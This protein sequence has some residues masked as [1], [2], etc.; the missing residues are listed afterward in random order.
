MDVSRHLGAQPDVLV[1]R[2]GFRLIST[3]RAAIPV[4]RVRLNCRV[5]KK[6][7][8][9]T[10]TEFVLRAIDLGVDTSHDITQLLNLPVEVVDGVLG[11]LLQ[12]RHLLVDSGSG[13]SKFV[14]TASGRTLAAT[15]VD[16]RVIPAI[17]TYMIDGLSGEPLA[18]PRE[19]II[20]TSEVDT[21]PRLVLEADEDPSLEFGPL[22]SDRFAP[23]EPVGADKGVSLLTILDVESTTKQYIDATILLFESKQDASDLF[24]RVC[25]DGRADHRIESLVRE[26]GI[27]RSMRVEARIDED[28][29]RVDRA[30]PGEVSGMRADD[31]EVESIL[32]E[33]WKLNTVNLADDDD[34]S[35]DVRRARLRSRLHQ[36]PVRKLSLTEAS[37]SLEV[38]MLRS[39]SS[40][41]ISAS[42]L[43]AADRR[44][45]YHELLNQ[46]IGSGCAVSLETPPT[47]SIGRATETEL[48]ALRKEFEGKAIVFVETKPQN[49]AGYV[50]L[51]EAALM[52]TPGNPFIEIASSAGRLGDD[53]PTLIEGRGPVRV[54]LRSIRSAAFFGR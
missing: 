37:D 35:V 43:W 48:I 20:S 3:R 4:W 5:L 51:D 39:R 47:G 38:R 27:L 16:E 29:R 34:E 36:L 46:V 26:L 45:H 40:V 41:A 10:F 8:V 9:D 31:N 44:D 24:L 23:I 21:E 17:V 52:L 28:R 11:E 33:I 19:L 1:R 49:E 14:L 25:V 7:H 32:D 30:L 53:R 50:V 54:I 15:L 13:E 42:R 18:V 6:G 12:N 2:D 22:D